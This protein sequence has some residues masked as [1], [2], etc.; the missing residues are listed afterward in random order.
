MGG[1]GCGGWKVEQQQV[2]QP[3]AQ[4]SKVAPD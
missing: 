2:G 4:R 1:D 3:F